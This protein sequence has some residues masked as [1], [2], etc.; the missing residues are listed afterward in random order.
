MM[1]AIALAGIAY[2]TQRRV[3]RLGVDSVVLLLVYVAGMAI[4][5]TQQ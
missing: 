2:R 1:M 4:L 5:L 3:L